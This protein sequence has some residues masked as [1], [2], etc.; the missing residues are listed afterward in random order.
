MVGRAF[1]ASEKVI[2]CLVP[3]KMDSIVYYGMQE[4]TP[5]LFMDV[6]IGEDW[7]AFPYMCLRA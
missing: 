4:G 3:L 1:W 6:R 5:A 7:I 2:L